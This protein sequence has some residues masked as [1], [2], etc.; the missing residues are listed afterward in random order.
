MGSADFIKRAKWFR[1][2]FG[3]GM[4]QT[5]FMAGCAAYALTYNFPKLVQVHAFAEQ[6]EK[7][8]RDI[9]VNILSGA[10]TCMV[11]WFIRCTPL[12]IR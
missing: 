12:S 8:L 4:R 6:L 1:K 10:E 7:G 9:G 3:G 11:G 5:G 2:L